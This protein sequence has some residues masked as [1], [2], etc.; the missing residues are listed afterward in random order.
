M[1]RWGAVVHASHA[2]AEVR[3]GRKCSRNEPQQPMCFGLTSFKRK[4][5]EVALH[6]WKKLRSKDRNVL[7][8]QTQNR[9]PV[10]AE[11]LSLVFRSGLSVDDDDLRYLPFSEC[12]M[13]SVAIDNTCSR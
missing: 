8:V 13:D 5:R 1:H 9:K 7:R 11:P 4:M 10:K 2:T 12:Y 6:L 3:Q